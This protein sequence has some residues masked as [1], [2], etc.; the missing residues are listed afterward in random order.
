MGAVDSVAGALNQIGVEL[1]KADT[2]PECLS[3]YTGRNITECSLEEIRQRVGIGS[4]SSV[5]IK[6]KDKHKTFTG[7]IVTNESDL[8]RVQS[9]SGKTR[10]WVCDVVTFISEHRVYVVN[11]EVKCIAHYDGDESIKPD[12]GAVNEIVERLSQCNSF[13]IDAYAVDVGVLDTGKTAVVEVN[14]G[15]GL[16]AYGDITPKDY[17]D[18]VSTRWNQLVGAYEEGDSTSDENID[19]CIE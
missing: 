7:F 5:F 13:S 17:F 6:P 9:V 3:E 12:R 10:V 16:G 14:E 15:Y 1:P 18:L 2:Y 4:V 11:G 8:Y 19:N